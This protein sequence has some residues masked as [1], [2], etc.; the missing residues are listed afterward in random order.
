MSLFGDSSISSSQEDL[1][2]IHV[3]DPLLTSS[4]APKH[5]FLPSS[6]EI[7]QS[8]SN[9]VVPTNILE[10]PA[11]QAISNASHNSIVD[12]INRFIN[13][14]AN[15]QH[16]PSVNL[17][18]EEEDLN[19]S[20]NGDIENNA[21]PI[22]TNLLDNDHILDLVSKIPTLLAKFAAVEQR[23]IDLDVK[24]TNL[25]SK[26]SALESSYCDLKTE[27][28][29]VKKEL[30]E[31]KSATDIRINETEQHGRS[32]SL[33]I[34]NLENVPRNLHNYKF[35]QYVLKQLQKHFPSVKVSQNDIDVSHILYFAAPYGQDPVVIV[36]FVN[37]DLRNYYYDLTLSDSYNGDVYFS[38]HLSPRNKELF[39]KAIAAT[40][41]DSVWFAKRKVH[42]I[43]NGTTRII[44]K[45]SDLIAA[46]S[47]DPYMNTL[48]MMNPP[49][50]SST[51]HPRQHRPNQ[52]P[53][54]APAGAAAS[55][56]TQPVAGSRRMMTRKV[57]HLQN[58]SR[59][60]GVASGSANLINRNRHFH[61]N[62]RRPQRHPRQNFSRPYRSAPSARRRYNNPR[63][64]NANGYDQ[65]SSNR[66]NNQNIPAAGPNAN[67]SNNT[68]SAPN[69]NVQSS[70][71]SA[72]VN[73]SAWNSVP[74]AQTMQHASIYP[75]GVFPQLPR[76]PPNYP[77]PLLPGLLPPAAFGVGS[78]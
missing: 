56:S 42:A 59:Q 12:D 57:S 26:Y 65:R 58:R 8:S 4:T 68:V 64:Y 62:N 41:R 3:D 16:L 47:S 10:M 1:T 53:P 17:L 28:T 69:I 32:N 14:H 46:T 51:P 5:V 36:K 48:N 73:N 70:S 20:V 24:C 11:S 13:P 22:D 33:L 61:Q 75:N 71:N 23:N 76:F 52:N 50:S 55:T 6:V 7:V 2:L 67:P 72:G 39:D 44:E 43:I 74:L 19:L 49:L 35:S 9:Q 40:N 34:H 30:S 63:P 29:S 66:S 54:V 60:N 45:E 77:P 25:T 27:L 78:R 38:D 31:H 15:M 37:R 21:L 18:E